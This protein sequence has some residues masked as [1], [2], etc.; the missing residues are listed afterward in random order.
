[1]ISAIFLHF[2]VCEYDQVA[3]KTSALR[4]I[5]AYIWG[6]SPSTRALAVFK[7]AS[8]PKDPNPSEKAKTCER[9]LEY[10]TTHSTHS[11]QTSTLLSYRLPVENLPSVKLEMAARTRLFM[12]VECV[13]SR[14]SE[15]ATSSDQ[16][17]VPFQRKTLD[18]QSPLPAPMNT[19]SPGLFLSA[20]WING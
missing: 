7:S 1:M 19:A 6:H 3:N 8:L 15:I 13:Q 4:S 10:L 5:F 12:P 9:G 16:L 17:G 11:K 20:Q 18:Q 2:A 14:N